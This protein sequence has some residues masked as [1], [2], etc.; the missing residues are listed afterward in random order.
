M[1]APSSGHGSSAPAAPSS[2]PPAFCQSQ[3]HRRPRP[4]PP[5]HWMVACQ[6][7]GGGLPG[8]P[9]AIPFGVSSAEV[10]EEVL[11]H[12]LRYRRLFRDRAGSFWELGGFDDA[13]LMYFE[14]ADL[15]GVPRPVGCRSVIS[16]RGR[17]AIRRASI[18]GAIRWAAPLSID[19]P[20]P[21]EVVR[22]SGGPGDLLLWLRAS[23]AT[24]SG[25]V[26]QQWRG[27]PLGGPYDADPPRSRRHGLRRP[28]A[29]VEG[30]SARSTH[31]AADALVHLALGSGTS[32]RKPAEH[33][34]Q[35]VR[36]GFWWMWHAIETLSSGLFYGACDCARWGE[37]WPSRGR[38]IRP[39]VRLRRRLRACRGTERRTT[40]PQS[41]VVVEL[42]A[43]RMR[44]RAHAHSIE[45]RPYSVA[46]SGS[47]RRLLPR[48]FRYG[49]EA[50]AMR[51]L[52]RRPVDPGSAL[53]V[54]CAPARSDR[55]ARDARSARRWPGLF[56]FLT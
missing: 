14:D 8:S 36:V 19:A 29:V 55:T 1:G 44:S 52:A 32:G 27:S 50:G 38:R 25:Y 40:S 10:A 3:R 35:H 30:G 54:R 17:V 2:T 33:R 53:A 31:F 20:V 5:R 56:S 45:S 26:R 11:E 15:A 4:G 23:D 16:I 41:A 13:I 24:R 9:N 51:N 7:I 6:I 21:Q 34:R 12:E 43:P 42:Y 47:Q 48:G 28:A 37:A 22:A 18:A 39:C 46:C 49:E